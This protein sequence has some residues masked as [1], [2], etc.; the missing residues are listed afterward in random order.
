MTMIVF[1]GVVGLTALLA[2]A[3][4]LRFGRTKA[5]MREVFVVRAARES[6]TELDVRARL[7][8]ALTPFCTRESCGRRQNAMRRREHRSTMVRERLYR[9]NSHVPYGY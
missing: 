1:S 2:L 5:D 6:A 9:R 7:E 4:M 8:R 3:S